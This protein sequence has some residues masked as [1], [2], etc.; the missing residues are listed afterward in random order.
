MDQGRMDTGA[1]CPVDSMVRETCDCII[2]DAPTG[3]I[4]LGRLSTVRDSLRRCAY[5]V[6]MEAVMSTRQS[7]AKPAE[8]SQLNMNSAGI[9]VGATSHFVAVPADRAEQPVQEFEAFTA[10]LYRLAHWLTEC[11]VQT[12]AM[13]STGVYWIPL[14]EVLEER[15]FQVMLVD[16]RRIK[17]VPGR[18]TDVVDCQW[19][20][21]LHSYGLLSG[22]FRPDGDIRRLRSYL[23][24]R[25][26]LVEYASHHIQHMHKALTQMNVKL[27]HV[28]RDITGK[29]G[30]DI[31]EA[32]AGGERDPRRLARL[33]DPRIKADE[34]TIARS[35]RGHWR[36]EHIF[37]LT[38]A[39][40]LYRT[41]Q[42]KCYS[43]SFHSCPFPHT[44]RCLDV[45]QSCR[46]I[47]RGDDAFA[48]A[49]ALLFYAIEYPHSIL[50]E[51]GNLMSQF[52]FSSRSGGDD[53]EFGGVVPQ[54][55]LRPL[56]SLHS[57]PF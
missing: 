47:N 46:L 17:N 28:I 9:D 49:S 43:E 53:E 48:Q 45:P 10:D 38:Q 12:V 50:C 22:A 32:I 7:S 23:R 18:K 4:P 27:Q 41:Y 26:M 34:A 25:A 6:I 30:M 15:G 51:E 5:T 29:T 8:L 20:Q 37:E 21:Q 24:Q 16:P 3:A 55:G 36:E 56:Q 33:R 1:Y 19:L 44:G 35:L 39:L 2:G 54:G 40:E 42:D 52:V 31:M 57:M 13:E 14:F 11:G